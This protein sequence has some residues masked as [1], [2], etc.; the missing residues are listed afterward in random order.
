MRASVMPNTCSS[1][2][3]RPRSF[4]DDEHEGT[5]NACEGAKNKERRRDL[6]AHCAH[7]DDHCNENTR[8]TERHHP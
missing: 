1:L 2:G 4:K 5:C 6:I 3:Q 7:N 8:E